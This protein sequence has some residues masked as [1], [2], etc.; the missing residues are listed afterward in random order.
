[1]DAFDLAVGERF[2]ENR[3]LSHDLLEGCFARA[4]LLTDVQVYEEYPARY[5]ED[6]RRRYRWI[7]GDWQL[8]RWLLPGP[9]GRDGRRSRNPLSLLCRWKLFDN[10]RRSL[11]PA[12]LVGLLLVAWAS[13]SPAWGWTLAGVGCLVVP[14]MTAWLPGVVRKPAD[15]ALARH[16]EG[17]GRSLG[18]QLA[19]ALQT[20]ACLPYEAY[21]SLSAIV[22]T[23]VRLLVTRRRLLEW[24]PSADHGLLAG[25]SLAAAWARM[26]I[27]PSLAVVAGAGLS[28]VRPES[29][30]PAAPILLLWFTAPTVAWLVSRP[31]SRPAA[32]L[33][34][35]QLQFLSGIAR[36]TWGFFDTYVGPDDHWL[37]PDNF[38]E[39]PAAGVAHRTSPTNMGLALL[40][41]LSACDF[42]YISAGRLLDRTARAFQSMFEMERHRGHFYNWYSTQSLAPLEPRFISSV[43][44]GNLAGHLMT[45]R[46]GLLALAGEPVLP[47]RAFQGLRDT[48]DLVADSVQG[49]PTATMTRLQKA[50]GAACDSPPATVADG[51]LVLERLAA[52]SGALAAAL[53]TTPDREASAWAS[54]LAGQCRDI[55]D[56]LAHL[57]PWTSLPA[58]AK[59]QTHLPGF[60]SI[61]TLSDLAALDDER[62]G[63]ARARIALLNRLAAQSS[64]LADME[65]DFLFDG[66]RHLLS[67][68]YNV[69]ER[70]RDSGYYDLLASEA[71]FCTFVGI[72]QGHLPQESWFALGRLLTTAAGEPVLL[73]WSGSMFEYLMPL[74]VM[75]GYDE[76]LLDQTCKAAVRCQIEY[77][78]RR[79]VPWGIS[80]SGYNMLDARLTYQ[81]R[82]FGVPGLGLQRGLA[83]DLVIAPYASALALMVAPEEACANLQR[84]A[85]EGFAGEL[86]FYEAID[87]TPA[88]LPRGQSHALV[89]SYMAHHQGMTILSLAQVLLDGRMQARFASDPACQATALLLQERIPR[90]T[91]LNL[92]PTPASRRPHG[93]GRVRERD[94]VVPWPRHPQAGGAA[95]LERAVSPRRHPRGRRLQPVEGPGP[96]PLARGRDVG[97]LGDVL[98]PPRRRHRGVLVDSAPAHAPARRSVRDGVLGGPRRVPEPD[99]SD[100]ELHR[101]RGVARG[102]RRAAPA[103]P[104]Q[105]RPHAQDDRGHQLRRGG[106]RPPRGRRAAPGLQ[107]SL[108]AD[109]NRRGPARD[110][111]HQA[112]AL[113][114]RGGALDVPPHGGAWGRGWRRPLVRNRPPAIPRPRANARRSARDARERS[115][116]G[117]RRIGAR[118]DRGDPRAVHARTGRDDHD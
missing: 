13:L 47:A 1:M 39:A 26:W 66:T 80:E 91:A 61:P 108:R 93:P 78:K 76:T 2:P 37:P 15:V 83:D 10:L 38:Q 116:R 77:A 50:L 16:L 71:R 19:Q 102:R 55:I 45:L 53:A 21:F 107:Q 117:Q 75:P 97:Q 7:R 23:A 14:A 29:L 95:A 12:A 114:R 36:R 48:F 109:G 89:R 60:T 64:D 24:T 27:A 88:R 18:R 63:P 84:L 70:R 96:H 73:S 51:R 98:L 35:R 56:D 41:N 81:Y 34:G 110:P 43:D 57:A 30:A 20:L 65:W 49:A 59:P 25:Q 87:Y 74:V 58:S 101:N 9:P 103:A 104:D 79:G 4:G 40:A 11:T 118:S 68:G 90:A 115:A 31:L 94:A 3:I 42:G 112:P 33:T 44:S 111:L 17:N 32:R 28:M 113:A 22:R 82:A 105:L 86:G 62:A 69:G 92:P 6:V 46:Q 100:R 99:Q 8:W 52:E 5:E 85:A 54:A 106:A 67:I 72:A